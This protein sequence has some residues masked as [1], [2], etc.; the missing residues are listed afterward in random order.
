MK[1]QETQ[2]ARPT[3]GCLSVPLFNQKKRNRIP[4]TSA[5]SENE[6]FSHSEYTASTSSAASLST[7]GTYRCYQA[8]GPP[9]SHQWN[10]QG[11]S[12]STPP[13]QYGS[14]RPAPGPAPAMRTYTSVPHPYKAGGTSSKMGQPS[15]SVRQQ[16]FRPGVNSRQSNYQAQ[17]IRESAQNKA[18]PHTGFSQ[19]GQ[20]S[21]YRPPNPTQYSQQPR[22]APAP[23]SPPSRP[24]ARATQPQSNSWN[25]TNSFGPQRSPFQ[26]N[27]STNQSQTV[28]QTQQGTLPE[29]PAMENSLRILT[30]VIDGMRHWSQFK[31]KVPYLFEI[32]ATL[33]SA[34]TLG[35]HGAKNFL[36]RD[37]REVV[38]CVFYENEQE[39]PRLIRGQVHRCVGNYDRSRDVLMCVSVRPGLPSELRNAQEAVKACDAEM[40]ALVKSL[41]E[42]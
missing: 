37:G 40:R 39:L 27:R 4:L 14:N 32:F 35:R 38:Q 31:D 3:A 26:G 12:Q 21:S 19:M 42:V 5:P 23:V 28:R 10:R 36:M 22:P 34:V 8:S 9:Q 33:D 41:S 7:S 29:K 1:R 20:Q 2:P 13:Q 18:T 24:S 16:D 6:F 30:A 25:F 17:H 15:S 11:I